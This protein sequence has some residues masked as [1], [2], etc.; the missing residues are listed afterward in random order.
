MIKIGSYVRMNWRSDS[1]L[2]K[3]LR[4][5]EGWVRE[6]PDA[7]TD[8]YWVQLIENKGPDCRNLRCKHCYAV[9]EDEIAETEPLRGEVIALE[10][11]RGGWSKKWRFGRYKI[12]EDE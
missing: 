5:Q 8:F 9:Y 3:D 10:D 6:L 4:I 7:K 12:G 11:R 1:R 2:G